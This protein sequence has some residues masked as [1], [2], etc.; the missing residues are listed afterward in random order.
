MKVIILCAGFHGKVLAETIRA[1][2][3]DELVAYLDDDARLTGTIRGGLPVL[4]P[5]SLLEAI[6]GRGEVD[7]AVIGLGNLEQLGIRR[8][9][10]EA[11]RKIGLKL[12]QV[13]HPSAVVSSS[14][15]CGDGVFLA[16][17]SVVHVD[18][19]IGQNVCVYTGSTID[20]DNLIGDHVFIG[21]GVHTAGQVTIGAGAYLGPGT[22]V[23]SGCTIGEN[24]I[25]GAGS[26]VVRNI[27]SNVIA[28][29][30]PA[31]IRGSVDDWR[32]RKK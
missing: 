19:R 20:H 13:I 8:Q 17:C 26:V 7:A 10:F 4:G 28:H 22:I 25:I 29:G 2:G 9:I 3:R 27:P 18:S 15:Q 11:S 14:A 12:L 24:S 32:L 21:P 23:A 6:A 31:Q 30:A 16:P 5:I 1:C